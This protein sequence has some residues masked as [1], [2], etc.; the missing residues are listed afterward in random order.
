MEAWLDF[1]APEG[2]EADRL[3]KEEIAKTREFGE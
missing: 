3:I 2:K 1:D